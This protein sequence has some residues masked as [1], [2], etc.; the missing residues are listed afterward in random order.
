MDVTRYVAIALIL[1]AGGTLQSAAGFGYALLSVTLLLLLGLAPY[2]AIPMVTAATTIQGLTGL[3]YHRRDVPWRLV[4]VSALLVL[5]T[6]PLGVFLLGQ[7]TMFDKGQVRQVFGVVALM[8]VAV[9][10]FWQPRPREQLHPAWTAAAMLSGGLLAGLCGMAGPP[11]V[12][13]A[14]SHRWPSQ[15]IRATLW[16]IFLTMTPLGIFFLYQRFGSIVLE[17]ALV[18]LAMTPAVLLGAIPGMWIGNRIPQPWLRRIAVALLV[19]LATY[20]V[21][22][23]LLGQF[24]TPC[25]WKGSPESTATFGIQNRADQLKSGSTP[26]LHSSG[27]PNVSSLCPTAWASASNRRL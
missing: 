1:A 25:R 26:P 20:M 10:V 23:P 3:W 18:A 13:W 14:M 27:L 21:C 11:V 5:V 2:E 24:Q 9:Y 19:A 12:L 4:G 22:Q 8:V 17:S 16:A 6:I 7:L 15:R